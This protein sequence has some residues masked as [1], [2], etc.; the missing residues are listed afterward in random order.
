MSALV[1]EVASGSTLCRLLLPRQALTAQDKKP[2]DFRASL[3]A[4]FLVQLRCPPPPKYGKPL[5]LT[6][7]PSITWRRWQRITEHEIHHRIATG[8]PE[9]GRGQRARLHRISY[10]LELWQ[11]PIVAVRGIVL[12]VRGHA[13]LGWASGWIC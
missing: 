4:I 2:Q 1:M 12:V 3:E 5:H 8:S 10:T 9:D 13:A 6:A 7:L 11:G